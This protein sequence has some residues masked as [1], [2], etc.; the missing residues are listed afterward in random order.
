LSRFMSISFNVLENNALCQ[1]QISGKLRGWAGNL[2][3]SQTNPTSIVND[4]D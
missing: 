1:R 3:D 4:D 2:L